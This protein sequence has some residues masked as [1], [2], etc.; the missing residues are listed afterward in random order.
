M[1]RARRQIWLQALPLGVIAAML[2]AAPAT[3]SAGKLYAATFSPASVP[4]GAFRLTATVT[5]ESNPQGT[6]GAN[7]L[8]PSG[9]TVTGIASVATSSGATWTAA[10][11]TCPAVGTNTGSLPCVQLRG[12]SLSPTQS[13]TVT[14]DA[15]S[16]PS[17]CSG[18]AT[19]YTWQ[20][21][22]RQDNSFK[23]NG[24]ELTLDA[25]T[26]SLKTTVT[27]SVAAT[28]LVF[29]AQPASALVNAPITTTAYNTPPGG[30]VEVDAL[31][32]CGRL[33][34][35]GAPIAIT[36]NEP[37]YAGAT[38]SGGAA[39]T[40]S[41]GR[42]LFPALMVNAAAQGYTL[43]AS[44]GADTAATS[45][46]FDISDAAAPNCSQPGA[47]PPASCSTTQTSAISS[48]S[49]TATG[50]PNNPSSATLFE[51]VNVGTDTLN[52]ALGAPDPSWYQYSI[53][54]PFWSKTDVYKLVPTRKTGGEEA[55]DEVICYGS[56]ADFVQ[57]GGGMAPAATLPDGTA[58]FI[59]RLPNCG[60]AG[61]TVCVQSRAR[62]KDATAPFGYD[63]VATAFV[64]EGIAADPWARC[65]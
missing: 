59:G 52:C 34:S 12:T 42:A 4:A 37:S 32:A 29:A 5:N 49:I 13:V 54:S 47:N 33:A 43:T 3:A 44:D 56:S 51:N 28:H 1:Q 41:G 25:N 65:C 45:H 31:N 35:S 60:T 15:A 50:D 20:S 27:N 26:S 55:K 64:P 2:G 57:A 16:A 8:I 24:N 10:I 53:D 14:L 48:L 6:T 11:G 39:V 46:A 18:S 22:V 36:L 38:L 40:P 23:G 21:D 63:L 61:A 9:L 7:L 58:G 30:P 17:D 19:T 62:V